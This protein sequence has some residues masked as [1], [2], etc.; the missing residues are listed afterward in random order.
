MKNEIEMFQQAQTNPVIRERFLM[1]KQKLVKTICF[2][3]CGRADEDLIQEGNIGLMIAFDKFDPEIGKF[4]TYAR[5]WIFAYMQQF[6]WKQPVVRLG[7]R[8]RNKRLQTGGETRLPIISLTYNEEGVNIEIP[9]GE[10]PILDVLQQREASQS[11][12]ESL[13]NIKKDRTREMIVAYYGLGEEDNVN[14]NVLSER[15]S[16]SKQRCQQIISEE[17]KRMAKEYPQLDS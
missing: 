1:K 10:S 2:R 12:Q 17:I 3:Y 14:M 5:Q 6:N 11:L 8:I 7:K 4:D 13:R 9:S 16:V 15:Y